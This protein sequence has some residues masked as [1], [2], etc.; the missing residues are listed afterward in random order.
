M[1]NLGLCYFNSVGVP[2]NDTEARKW[3]IK[4]RRRGLRAGKADGSG[5]NPR[6]EQQA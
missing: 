2:K 1:Y 4:K 3:L 6:Q 5:D